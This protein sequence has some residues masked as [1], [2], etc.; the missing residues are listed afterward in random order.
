MTIRSF[1]SWCSWRVCRHCRNSGL[2]LGLAHGVAFASMAA[3]VLW[4]FSRT[5]NTNEHRQISAGLL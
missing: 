5:A 3:L 4:G 1:A 2:D